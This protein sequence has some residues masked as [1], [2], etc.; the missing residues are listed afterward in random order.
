M[1]FTFG[2]EFHTK[3]IN[4][5]RKSNNVKHFTKPKITTSP[6]AISTLSLFSSPMI[7]R[8]TNARTGCSACGK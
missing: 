1:T 6:N 2:M 3:K 5:Q 7:E 8:V 4:M